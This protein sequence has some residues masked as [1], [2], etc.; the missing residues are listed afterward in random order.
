MLRWDSHAALCCNHGRPCSR[1]VALQDLTEKAEQYFN[2]LRALAALPNV[3]IKISMLCYADKNWAENT[4][5]C[6]HAPPDDVACMLPACCCLRTV[7]R[8]LQIGLP[9]PILSLTVLSATT[10]PH[11]PSRLEH[12]SG[13]TAHGRPRTS[14]GTRKRPHGRSADPPSGAGRDC[15]LRRR[16]MHVC[17]QLPC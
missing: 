11:R 3:A 4:I 12:P 1:W 13:R 7:L 2:G 6:T 15:D 8:L 10:E 14:F 9:M 5:V 17:L 16:P